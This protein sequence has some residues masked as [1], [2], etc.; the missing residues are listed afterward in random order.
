MYFD[1]LYLALRDLQSLLSNMEV[2]HIHHVYRPLVEVWRARSLTFDLNTYSVH[3]RSVLNKLLA[4][5]HIFFTISH[6]LISSG[7]HW[8]RYT[9]LICR[10][11]SMQHFLHNKLHY[12]IKLKYI[13][14]I[15]KHQ[16]RQILNTSLSF[17]HYLCLNTS[18]MIYTCYKCIYLCIYLYSQ[19]I[20]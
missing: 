4:S 18:L 8:W 9:F 14:V 12:L 13:L 6:V 16:D 3:C 19:I 1:H 17:S 15:W 20:M 5:F 11:V 2:N 7:Q 10:T